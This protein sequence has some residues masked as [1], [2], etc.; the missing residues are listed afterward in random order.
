MLLV[1]CYQREGDDDDI[2]PGD[3]DA[4]TDG[5]AGADGDVDADAD[6]TCDA[7]GWVA[8]ACESV[9]GTRAITF[10]SP[11]GDAAP[12]DGPLDAQYYVTNGIVALASNHLLA[13]ADDQVITSDDAG[14]SWR[15]VTPIED[16]QYLTAAGGC[17]AYAFGGYQSV[18]RIVDG[19]V[20][21]IGQAVFGDDG[22]QDLW[23]DPQDD[24]HVFALR[25][26][27][28]VLLESTDAGGGWLEIGACPDTHVR[29]LAV[30]AANLD[31]MSC[32]THEGVW[33]SLDRGAGWERASG[34]VAPDARVPVDELEIS[35][36]DGAVVWAVQ[37][38]ALYRSVDGGATFDRVLARD[39]WHHVRA[40][41]ADPGRVWY[42]YSEHLFRYD[43][44]DAGPEE[45]LRTFQDSGISSFLQSPADPEVVYLGLVH[46]WV[47]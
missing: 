3:G 5:D 22:A 8:P 32:G 18:Q 13:L 16:G 41:I 47:D 17:R 12:N 20:T 4:D 45:S 44:G 43:V 21:R 26:G 39:V 37:G 11:E 38:D 10:I 33:T 42:L 24:A 27:D 29:A 14:C 9:D 34:L 36:V 2:G 25:N 46:I 6:G 15:S 30:D 35:P 40:D 1:A 23:V 31:H 7:R 19:D 28:G